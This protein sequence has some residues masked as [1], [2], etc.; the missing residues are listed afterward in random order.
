MIPVG[1]FPWFLP[2]YD[3][4]AAT[5][6]CH[7]LDATVKVQSAGMEKFCPAVR[8]PAS[9]GRRVKQLHP[10][11]CM[12]LLR[13]RRFYQSFWL[14]HHGNVLWQMEQKRTWTH[15]GNHSVHL[16]AQRDT[17]TAEA[18]FTKQQAAC[19]MIPATLE[20]S[21]SAPNHEN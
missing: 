6:L 19:S 11:H 14:H 15:A 7:Q 21:N 17:S 20:K 9:V 12:Q 4:T 10:N 16:H 1:L 2:I 18:A 8:R 5:F 13:P 3:T